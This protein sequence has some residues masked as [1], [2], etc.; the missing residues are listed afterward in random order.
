VAT[1]QEIVAATAAMD[2]PYRLA[3]LLACHCRLR[4]SE[5][6]GLQRYH[7]TWTFESSAAD[8]SPQVNALVLTNS[9]PHARL[10]TQRETS[11]PTRPGFELL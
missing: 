7:L 9:H 6:L 11:R 3:V 1:V 4:G 5:V 10:K 8:G 2:E